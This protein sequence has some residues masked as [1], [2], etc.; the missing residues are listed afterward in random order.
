MKIEQVDAKI[1]VIQ[2]T[3]L[4]AKDRNFLGKKTTSDPYVDVFSLGRQTIG[5][6]KTQYKTLDPV[7]NH[8]VATTFRD[9][10]LEPPYVLL[11]IWD[12]DKF[13]QPDSMGTIRVSFDL[14]KPDITEWH[15]V[16][17]DSAKNASGKVQLRIQ[18][19][20]HTSRALVRGNEFE[21]TT[22]RLRVGLAWDM[23]PGN[24]NI[25]L[26]VSCVAITTAGQISMQDTVYYGNTNNP[27]ETVVH[28]GDEREGDKE[29]DDETIELML[30]HI[31]KHVL[32]MY[33][34][35]T[36][37][38]P[39]HLLPDIKSTVLR[40]YDTTSP[41]NPTT[42]CTFTP[43]QDAMS[44]NATAMFMVRIARSAAG[45]S[46]NSSWKLKPISDTHPT[47]RDFG[48]LMPYLKSYTRD[49]IPNI[50]VDPTER[51]A[52]L[53]KGGNIRLTDYCK[54]GKLPETVTF[55][56]AWDVTNG[57]NIDLDA[58]AICLD[59]GLNLVDQVWFKQLRSQDSSIVHHGDEREGDEIG[60]DEKMDITLGQVNEFIHYIGIVINSYSGQ[61]LD[62]VAGAS[63][64]LFDPQTNTDMA[65]YA[66][67]NTSDLDK[68]TALV[69][70]CL[71]RGAAPGEWNLCIMSEPAQG[72]TAHDNVGDL[73]NYLKRFPPQS[74]IGTE[75]EEEIV[76]D[77]EMPTF[78]PLEDEEID[79]S[80]PLPLPINK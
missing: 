74:N 76:V 38:T 41:R 51:V 67:T 45:S 34:I 5:K 69:V 71:Y 13:S 27:N 32:A 64:H 40:V 72:R 33:I 80:A 28:S 62:D 39:G 56:L 21:L 7:W 16:P 50:E 59:K 29:G 36:V 8:T 30:D 43:A 65:T 4:V 47:A 35:L 48:S 18:L 53:R 26:D 11:K 66:M 57:K 44:R 2:G 58:S 54:G 31:P 60:D 68:H 42:L 25:D 20:L 14:S 63:C 52:I 17:P 15:D 19:Q 61:E 73:Q 22:N 46:N 79:M 78:V 24:K 3:G 77:A 10:Q 49:L 23:L 70:A 6:T 12:E 1:T 37:V 9:V 55:G 75:K